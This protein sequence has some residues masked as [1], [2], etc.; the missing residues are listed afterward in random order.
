M[1]HKVCCSAKNTQTLTKLKGNCFFM[2][3]NTAIRKQ[4]NITFKFI[5]TKLFVVLFS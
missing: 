1:I 2:P 4:T 5:V 3:Q